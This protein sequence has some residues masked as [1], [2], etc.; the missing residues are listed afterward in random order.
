MKT[1]QR[2]GFTLLEIMIVVAL[3]GLLAAIAIPNFQKAIQTTQQRTCALNR[4]NIDGAKW[5]WALEHRKP[6]TATPTDTD[7][8]GKSAYIEHKPDC[9]ASG[10][11]SLNAVREKCT[12]SLADHV[13]D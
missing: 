10:E 8:F 12:C 7:L 5:Q 1:Q 13:N 6:P 2:A 9:P 4:R 11:Y 3:I